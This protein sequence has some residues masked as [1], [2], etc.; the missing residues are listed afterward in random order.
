M[1][2][3]RRTKAEEGSKVTH[4]EEFESFVGD[5]D[6]EPD[7]LCRRCHDYPCCCTVEDIILSDDLEAEMAARESLAES[8]RRDS[9]RSGLPVLP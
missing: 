7:E 1:K 6:E 9:A 3:T 8:L 5:V 4:K 2:R